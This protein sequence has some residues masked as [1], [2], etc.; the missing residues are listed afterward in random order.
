MRIRILLLCGFFLIFISCKIT[1]TRK[2]SIPVK[3][4]TG[5]VEILKKE[6]VIEGLKEEPRKIWLYLP[7]NYNASNKKY[8]VIYMQDAQNIFSSSNLNA[9]TWEV[10]KTLNKLYNQKGKGFIVVGIENG[11]DARV[12]EYSPWRN[13]KYGGG[14]GTLYINFLTK[15]LKPY[16]DATYKTNHEAKNT[17]IIG[18]SLGGLISF[19]GGL[20][21]PKVFGKIGALSTSFWF[22]K[23]IQQFATKN[24][25]Q[26]NTQLYLLVGDKEGANMVPD[27]ENMA[28]LLVDIGF[29]IKNIKT[30]I[31]PEGTHTSSFWKAEFLE[32]ITFL[33]PI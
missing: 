11:G 15:H 9:N 2:T 10:D 27:T 16:I 14:K 4:Q 6:F 29:S 31:A 20:K 17:A 8:D 1:P 28:K 33:Y 32:V 7:P 25:N 21:H 24:G 26:K 30:R 5:T 23:N 18:S 12:D 19:Y 13:P 22:S 3:E